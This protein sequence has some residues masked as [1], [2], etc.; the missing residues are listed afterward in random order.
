MYLKRSIILKLTKTRVNSILKGAGRIPGSFLFSGKLRV[1]NTRVSLRH[2]PISTPPSTSTLPSRLRW[3]LD[4]HWNSWNE[5][6]NRIIRTCLKINFPLL[7]EEC[8]NFAHLISLSVS[9]PFNC[10]IPKAIFCSPRVVLSR[11]TCY[12]R[13][14]EMRR[15]GDCLN[16]LK[17]LFIIPLH[18]DSSPRP[19]FILPN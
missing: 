16:W 3:N 12:S 15:E 2:N 10:G 7:P 11:G 6:C 18:H 17:C 14:D 5:K 19:V 4:T 1:S 13:T 9:T 8:I